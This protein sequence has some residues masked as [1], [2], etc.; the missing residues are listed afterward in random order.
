MTQLPASSNMRRW[1]STSPAGTSKRQARLCGSWAR[2]RGPCRRQSVGPLNLRGTTRLH[3]ATAISRSRVRTNSKQ[4][5]QASAPQVQVIR[6]RVA[7]VRTALMVCQ[8]QRR[9]VG[10]KCVWRGGRALHAGVISQCF[11]QA[12]G[13]STPGP[14][15]NRLL[16]TQARAARRWISRVI[17]GTC[18]RNGRRVAVRIGLARAA[19]AVTRS[20]KLC[21]RGVGQCPLFPGSQ[22]SVVWL[23][24]LCIRLSVCAMCVCVCVCVCVFVF[25]CVCVLRRALLSGQRS[26]LAACC[27]AFCCQTS[28]FARSSSCVCLACGS[29][30]RL[31]WPTPRSSRQP[32]VLCQLWM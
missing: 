27:V 16:L 6:G 5:A 15:A 28:R 10:Q 29:L 2:N 4:L 21:V 9:S 12:G 14:V 7:A 3:R 8:R 19:R 13:S 17:P 30:A 22:F 20:A 32:V 1:S 31:V 11:A 25:V 18:S 24:V 26:I 23:F